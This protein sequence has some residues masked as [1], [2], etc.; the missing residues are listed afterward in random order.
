MSYTACSAVATCTVSGLD[1]VRTAALAVYDYLVNHPDEIP[2]GLDYDDIDSDDA[3]NQ[4]EAYLALDS[5]CLTI[6][7]DSE[8]DFSNHDSEIFDFLSAHF[9]CLQ[10]SPYM[11]VHWSSIDSRTGADGGTSYYDR[12]GQQIDIHALLTAHLNGR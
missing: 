3:V 8:S 10:T 12:Q 4:I 11:E 7:Y 9:A 2:D 6:S 5:D 1:S